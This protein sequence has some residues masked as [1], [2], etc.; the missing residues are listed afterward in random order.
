[1]STYETIAAKYADAVKSR[2]NR[3]AVAENKAQ[4]LRAKIEAYRQI[5]ETY[6]QPSSGFSPDNA[7]MWKAYS[8]KLRTLENELSAAELNAANVRL[9]TDGVAK[10]ETM[11]NK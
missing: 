6:R 4:L 3:I 8:A 7:R 2:H 9:G 1:M 11:I 10:I 5:R